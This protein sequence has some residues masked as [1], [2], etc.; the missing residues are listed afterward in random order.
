MSR[1]IKSLSK[2][3]LPEPEKTEKLVGFR[4]DI[5]FTETR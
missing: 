3:A 4:P 2:S 1:K 5:Y